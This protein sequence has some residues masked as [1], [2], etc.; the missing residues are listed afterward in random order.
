M[1]ERYLISSHLIQ[2]RLNGF[3]TN[4]FRSPLEPSGKLNF[5]PKNKFKHPHSINIQV[6][7]H[8]SA[9]QN[10]LQVMFNGF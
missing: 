5:P 3:N 6:I 7:L 2:T 1:P 8:S 4:S 9:K 10:K